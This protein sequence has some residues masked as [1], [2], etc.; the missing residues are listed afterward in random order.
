MKLSSTPYVTNFR[1]FDI[2]LCSYH[3]LII[4]CSLLEIVVYSISG[5]RINQAPVFYRACWLDKTAW[6]VQVIDVIIRCGRFSVGI[7]VIFLYINIHLLRCSVKKTDAQL[8][9]RKAC[10][11]DLWIISYKTGTTAVILYFSRHANECTHRQD[12][13]WRKTV[14]DIFILGFTFVQTCLISLEINRKFKPQ[15]ASEALIT[16]ISETINQL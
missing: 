15:T 5:N 11:T 9:W 13:F 3:I 16:I 7:C 2:L 10:L 6:H 1:H 4:L 12:V 8:N 14:N